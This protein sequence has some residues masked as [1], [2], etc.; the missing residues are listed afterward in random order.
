[1]D[2]VPAHLMALP[3]VQGC[4]ARVTAETD[5]D[6]SNARPS[7]AEEKGRCQG[8]AE[9]IE[10]ICFLCRRSCDGEHGA[11]RGCAAG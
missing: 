11:H 7:G 2:A 1:M 4:D 9:D 3:G 8:D 6:R 10:S 5:D